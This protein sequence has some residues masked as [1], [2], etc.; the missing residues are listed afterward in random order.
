MASVTNQPP[1]VQEQNSALLIQNEDLFNQLKAT[2]GR[3]EQK[4]APLPKGDYYRL[5]CSSCLERVDILRE[6]WKEIL[7]KS[8]DGR[9]VYPQ[10]MTIETICTNCEK[11]IIFHGCFQTNIEMRRIFPTTSP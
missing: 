1:S 3:L 10:K 8:L 9:Y 2:R 5:I 4:D 11:S 6:K 7:P